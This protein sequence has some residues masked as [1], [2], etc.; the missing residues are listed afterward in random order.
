MT[1]ANKQHQKIL[2]AHPMQSKIAIQPQQCL[3][4]R[5]LN[6]V[7]EIKRLESAQVVMPHDHRIKS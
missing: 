1:S 3:V 2:A 6:K 5:G 7:H 4:Q